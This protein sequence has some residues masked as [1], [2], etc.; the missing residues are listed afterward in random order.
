M[1]LDKEGL[2]RLTFPLGSLSTQQAKDIQGDNE[3]LARA[4]RSNAVID[5]STAAWLAGVDE[6]FHARLAKHGLCV[7]RQQAEPAQKVGGIKLAEFIDSYLASR[8]DIKPT[9]RRKLQ[10]SRDRRV[11]HFGAECPI[12]NITPGDA[13]D[14]RQAL[15]NSELAEAT[16]SK[17]VKHAKQFFRLAHRKGVI[18]AN[19]FQNLRAG[20]R[21][22]RFASTFCG[23]FHYR[24]R[25][26]RSI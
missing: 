14:R 18:N 10:N 22:Q 8:K 24:P 3:R 21:T 23:K 5:P 9:S 12:R 2:K 7:A 26:C 25:D 20:G 4:R 13:D 11:T 15:V 19:P 17:A 16:I 6:E 1:S